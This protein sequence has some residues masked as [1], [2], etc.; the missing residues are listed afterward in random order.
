V[1]LWTG[2]EDGGIV[3]WRVPGPSRSEEAGADASDDRDPTPVA[4]L[5][6]HTDRVSAL[7]AVGDV[8]VSA[9][10]DG[11]VCAWSIA[12][13]ASRCVARRAMGGEGC[14]VTAL[15]EMR[16]STRGG[17]RCVAAACAACGPNGAPTIALL[18][19]R[20]L[21]P[22]NVDGAATL[23]APSDASHG[24]PISLACRKPKLATKTTTTTTPRS[25]T[26]GGCE[27]EWEGDLV[28]RDA[29]GRESAW[30]GPGRR[31]D[32]DAR[33][34]EL[35]RG[36]E[37]RART[38]A[39][40]SEED[41][42]GLARLG[43]RSSRV[44]TPSSAPEKEK[45]E[46]EEEEEDV[47][48]GLAATTDDDEETVHETPTSTAVVLLEVSTP[49]R[50]SDV[51]IEVT[52]D[53]T[54]TVSALASDGRT[55]TRRRASLSASWF[56]GESPP[57]ES[58]PG[59][60]PPPGQQ[61]AGSATA[62][63]FVGGGSLA[64]SRVVA[65]CDD[66][67]LVIGTLPG[68]GDGDSPS[69]SF[70][71]ERA[72]AGAV[73]RATEAAGLLVTGGNDGVVRVWS[74]DQTPTGRPELRASLRY[75]SFA[76]T[77]IIPAPVGFGCVA[78]R[79]ANRD[80]FPRRLHT[81]A[82]VHTGGKDRFV[83]TVDASGALGLV[84]VE[85]GR[86]EV[87]IP[88]V[89]GHPRRGPGSCERLAEL[90]LDVGRGALALRYEGTH[91]RTFN[92]VR[93]WDLFGGGV[94]DRDVVG[95]GAAALASALRST[96]HRASARG[97]P[98]WS[99]PLLHGDDVKISTAVSRP[100]VNGDWTQPGA[101][102]VIANAAHLLNACRAIVKKHSA[103]RVGIGTVDED[104]GV[105]GE[106]A[107][108]LRMV[109]AAAGHAWG[110]D[111]SADAAASRALRAPSP[112][113]PR[114]PGGD[115][116][117]SGS[118]VRTTRAA[119]G[120]GGA[121]TISA[122]RGD[123]Q[124]DL[125]VWGREAA[126]LRALALEACAASLHEMAP[127]G[128]GGEGDRDRGDL[129]LVRAFNASVHPLHLPTLASLYASPS[130]DVRAAARSLLSNAC[131]ARAGRPAH[132]LPAIFRE[133]PSEALRECPKASGLEAW[134]AFEDA[135]DDD[136]GL[137]VF[138]DPSRDAD[139]SRLAPRG[140]L[141]ACVAAAACLA[142]PPPGTHPALHALVA[143]ALLE[144]MRSCERVSLAGAAALMLGEGV[145]R[146]GWGMGEPGGGFLEET[147]REACDT[148]E[149]LANPSGIEPRGTSPSPRP[150]VTGVTGVT[151]PRMKGRSPRASADWT[152][153]RSPRSPGSPVGSS[154]SPYSGGAARNGPAGIPSAPR[155]HPVGTPAE[156]ATARDAID[157]LLF[158]AA[159]SNPAS[160]ATF[161][162]ARIQTAPPT[163]SSHVVALAALARVARE[164]PHPR[165]LLAPHVHALMNA[166][167]AALNP[168][169]AS[170][171]RNCLVAATAV[172]AELARR[173]P[174]VTYHRATS[175]LAVGIDSPA[176]SGG[177]VAIVYDLALAATWRTLVDRD[178]HPAEEARRFIDGFGAGFGHMWA[179]GSG[180]SDAGAES[181]RS[182]RTS[183][184]GWWSPFKDLGRG[185][186]GG[187]RSSGG[188]GGGGDGGDGGGGGALVSDSP[189]SPEAR[190]ARAHA[191]MAAIPVPE[192]PEQRYAAAAAAAATAMTAH[193]ADPPRKSFEGSRRSFQSTS[194]PVTPLT[195]DDDDD[196]A[197]I[198]VMA[199]DEKGERLAAYLDRRSVVRVWNVA[200]NS[201]WRPT[202]L[203][204]RAPQGVAHGGDAS[205]VGYSHSV[206]C[207]VPSDETSGGSN[208]NDDERVARERT[209]LA[210]RDDKTVTLRRGGID[211]SFGVSD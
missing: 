15:C 57:G 50:A 184:D 70:T 35:S 33:G 111:D 110:V 34:G 78:P 10:D 46:E 125:G 190:T 129:A 197:R 73:T 137:E 63:C 65:G 167:L 163:S 77:Q 37:G 19:P 128:G 123:A 175:R 186:R 115:E 119:V 101:P 132:A 135:F 209:S 99:P 83:F 171:R 107:R 96:C 121:V 140:C 64:P 89:A 47:E 176:P 144:L 141:G 203:F 91:D 145:E 191:A 112:R 159:R 76:V 13:G 174:N 17:V 178:D 84:D 133:T 81:S 180:T 177:T 206:R 181:P 8:V 158:A 85:L 161:L 166:V 16:S 93:V 86:C 201:V 108:A 173:L 202:S 92:R 74:L 104:G 134:G 138:R 151:S 66:G 149:A 122:P 5:S 124:K 80:E 7:C 39:D 68:G 210:W 59:E 95:G 98:A 55:R 49:G 12:K 11:V 157:S 3:Q 187:R 1:Q 20:T 69:S 155:R 120:A 194:P 30:G 199:W 56:P 162:S 156:R 43:V 207:V 94:M 6:G 200:S 154:R 189:T 165:E 100:P 40:P 131:N 185:R 79:P 193:R 41:D 62:T 208:E 170:L 24:V 179:T 97:Y 18:N 195:P 52:R 114:A 88:G 22:V 164:S 113:T 147:L 45:R 196:S 26:P 58:P 44:R 61:R 72:H 31:R 87:F 136:A 182:Q 82:G 14:R 42:A 32:D 211:A 90:L 150:S 75:H 106:A 67:D 103:G 204:T 21:A 160:F 192:T 172:V 25:S 168:A 4:F 183:G 117:S 130:A 36:C 105:D 152:D 126:T 127:A 29:S 28:A 53:A 2:G 71:I 116:A 205:A 153:R 54:V 139:S 23:S 169:N 48:E 60:S 51:E 198:E 146:I 143:P 118:G 188:D 27:W 102:Y 142:N 9:G 148:T 38:A 109:A